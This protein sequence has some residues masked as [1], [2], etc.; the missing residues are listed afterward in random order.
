MIKFDRAAGNQSLSTP[1]NATTTLG[2]KWALAEIVRFDGVV[3]GDVTQYHASTGGFGDAGSLNL[4]HYAAGVSGTSLRSRMAVYANTMANANTPALLST[5]QFTGGVHLIVTQRDG[6]TATMRSCP[7]LSSTPIDGSAVVQ[8]STTTN[9][10]IIQTLDGNGFKFA[11]RMNDTADRKCDQSMSRFF[12]LNDTLTDFEIARLAA[13]EEI[14][15]LGKNI[16]F[17][18]RASDVTDILDRGPNALPFSLAGTPAPTTSAEPSFAPAGGTGQPT[19]A[20]TVSSA[21]SLIVGPSTGNSAM[22]TFAG[23]LGGAQADAIDVRMIAPDGS[24]GNWVALQS[25]TIGASS[26]SGARAA[27]DGGPYTFQARSR[28][29]TTVLAESQQSTAKVL[30]GGVWGNCGSS[31]SDYL[32]TDKSGTGFTVAPNTAVISGATPTA[33]AMSTTGA[34]TRM[35]SELAAKAGK[36]II[37]L[38]YGVAG[39]TLRTWLDPNSTHRKNLAA[40]IAAMKGQLDGLYITVGPNDAAN[41]WITST[42][43]HLADMQKLIDD[44]RA[45]TTRPTDLPVVWVGGPPRPGLQLVQAERMRQAE[46]QIGNYPGVVY[47]QALQFATASDNVHLAPSLDGYAACGSMAM[48]QAGRFVYGGEDPKKVRGPS[49]ASITYTGT[50]VRAAVT[51]RDGTDFTPAA[52]GG[53]T[54]QNKQP[55]GSHVTLSGIAAQRVNA[56]LIEIECGV[57]LVD[58]I[59]KYLAEQAPSM[60]NAV[61]SNGVLPLPMTVEAEM[62][63]T[64]AAAATDTTAPVMSGAINLTNVTASGATLSFQAATDDVGVTGYEYSIG[65]VDY[66]NIGPDRMVVLNGLPAGTTQTIFIRAYDGAGNRSEP[67]SRSVTT[68]EYVSG[69][70]AVGQSRRSSASRHRYN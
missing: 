44:L 6:A 30:V 51:T 35:A 36:P 53:F 66:F 19:N 7:A 50:K 11:S 37:W 60:T 46:S 24:T 22:V 32:F 43:A 54:V 47:V 48:Y 57:T 39:T 26:Y 63:A 28:S 27:P 8:E 2:N 3:T 52:P 4:V 65:G 58:P 29:G 12:L 13:G 42:A 68:A 40:A 23:A 5:T 62:V 33:S 21:Q 64:Q 14:T 15:A 70:P 45:L 17:Y 31:S 38:N 59:V 20:I 61:Y 18:V 67:L 25:P 34:A 1:D 56:N 9:S 41:G 10:Q 16:V 69:P 55:D 49:I